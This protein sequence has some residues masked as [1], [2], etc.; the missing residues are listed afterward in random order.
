MT[1]E[2]LLEQ[3]GIPINDIV[4]SEEL[5]PDARIPYGDGSIRFE[6]LCAQIIGEV[7]KALNARGVLVSDNGLTLEKLFMKNKTSGDM[8]TLVVKNNPQGNPDLIFEE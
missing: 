4:P 6:D 7:F 2:E 8:E 5:P 3:T 1:P